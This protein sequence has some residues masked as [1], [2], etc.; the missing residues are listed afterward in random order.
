LEACEHII[1]FIND[2]NF[3]AFNKSRL[4]QSAVIRELGIIGEAAK[5]LTEEIRYKHNNIPW[6]KI[7][8]MKDKLTH[9]Y[10]TVDLKEVWNTSEKD[11]PILMNN[12]KDIL[13]SGNSE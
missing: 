10:F 6:K 1:E 3:E 7:A 8:G 2:V 9:G 11:I 5:N 13:K 12:I 4:I